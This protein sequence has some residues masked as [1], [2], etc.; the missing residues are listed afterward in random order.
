VGIPTGQARPDAG[1]LCRGHD[2]HGSAEILMVEIPLSDTSYYLIENRQ[3]LGYD[4]NL[5][6]SGVLIMYAD[7]GIAECR[8]GEAPVKLVNAHPS[9]PHLEG[10]AFDVGGKDSFQVSPL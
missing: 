8:H 5:P 6:G 3:P 4:K 9:V 7:D 2:Q 10:A 1:D